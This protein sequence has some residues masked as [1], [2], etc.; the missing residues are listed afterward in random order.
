MRPPKDE[1]SRRPVGTPLA[2]TEPPLPA[3]DT[4]FPEACAAA[5]GPGSKAPIPA[6]PASSLCPPARAGT[7]VSAPLLV[8]WHLIL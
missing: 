2:A 5:P 7:A 3:R 6:V 8:S 4:L 1:L